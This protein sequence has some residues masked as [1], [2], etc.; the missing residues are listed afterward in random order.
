MNAVPANGQEGVFFKEEELDRSGSKSV[1]H[2]HFAAPSIRRMNHAKNVNASAM[3]R[4][5]V[6][7]NDKRVLPQVSTTVFI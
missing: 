6:A 2:L 3:D 7:A 5:C 4:T 1:E